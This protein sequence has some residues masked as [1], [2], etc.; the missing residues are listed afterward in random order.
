MMTQWKV[1]VAQVVRRGI[2][3][4]RAAGEADYSKIEKAAKAEAEDDG[5]IMLDLRG[6]EV[7]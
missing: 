7:L 6:V 4:G 1:T 2:L 3:A 5:R